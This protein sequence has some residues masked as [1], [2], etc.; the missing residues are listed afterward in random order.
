MENNWKGL[1]S[2]TFFGRPTPDLARSLLGMVIAHDGPLGRC[3]GRVVE[4]EMYRGPEDRAAHSFGGKITPRTRV[5]YGPPGHAYV[6]FVYGMHYC[7]NVVTG[8]PGSP[9]AILIRALEP[10]QGIELMAQ[11]RHLEITG[12]VS[13]LCQLTNGPAKLAQ[14]LGVAQQEYGLAFFNSRLQ[15][16]HDWD[17]LA[18]EEIATGPRI[19]VNYAGEAAQYPWRFWIKNHLCVSVK[20]RIQKTKT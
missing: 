4:V 11:R 15:L 2:K 10:L 3:A 1:A 9:E 17:P 5:M 19:N 6:Y 14:A 12:P 16:Y 8:P 18:S 20:D 13:N 7:L